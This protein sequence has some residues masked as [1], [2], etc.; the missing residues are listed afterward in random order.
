M[1]LAS[2]ACLQ[3][4]LNI[5]ASRKVEAHQRINRLR[6]RLK[7]IDQPLVSAHLEVLLGVLVDERRS[8][9]RE[10]L[11]LRRKRHRAGDISTGPLGRLDDLPGGLI[12]DPMVKCLQFD[13]NSLLRHEYC[14]LRNTVLPEPP[15][16]TR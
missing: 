15:I 13:A 14:P 7:D 6:C 16:A 10:P 4:D 9:D 2:E 3:F 1:P 5:Y 8:H 12:K 11:D